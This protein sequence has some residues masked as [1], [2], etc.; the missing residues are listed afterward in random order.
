M[1]SQ[2]MWILVEEDELLSSGATLR[3]SRKEDEPMS[4]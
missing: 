1:K 3:V 4:S 2:R